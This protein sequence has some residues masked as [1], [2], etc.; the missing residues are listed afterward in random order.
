MIFDWKTVLF[1][2]KNECTYLVN[3]YIYRSYRSYR[4]TR[5][6]RICSAFRFFHIMPM[7]N[8]LIKTAQIDKTNYNCLVSFTWA[9]IEYFLQVQETD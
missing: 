4:S 3:I 7:L 8:L 6:P 5:V 2:K 1:I 9:F